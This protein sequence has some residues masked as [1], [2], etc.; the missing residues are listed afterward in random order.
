M[1]TGVLLICL[2]QA[3]RVA[4]YLMAGR[5]VYRARIHLGLTTDTYDATGQVLSQ[6][7]TVDLSLAEIERGAS[8]FVGQ[9][10]QRPPMYSAIKQDGQP[11]YKLARHGIEVE[12]E[13]RTVEVYDFRIVDW[14]PPVLATE[15]TCSKGTY[16]RSLAHD[17]GQL[18]GC[19][20]HLAELMR[21]ASGPFT[22]AEAVPLSRLMDSLVAGNWQEYLWPLD[23][24]LSSYPAWTVDEETARRI[25]CGQAIPVACSFEDAQPGAYRRAYSQQ[26]TLLAL[27]R[28][29]DSRRSWQPDKV[30]VND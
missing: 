11:L 15:I 21:I 9:I 3:T 12:R 20:A 27:L 4:E 8:S 16:I 25:R 22:L 24:A 5:K 7:S 19:G 10:K 13:A 23:V 14:S 17:L 18:L 30:F 1:A 2:G 28:Y 29:D 6:A 26:G